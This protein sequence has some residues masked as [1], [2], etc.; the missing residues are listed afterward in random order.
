[1]QKTHSDPLSRVIGEPLAET[2]GAH[3]GP[4][5]AMRF[6]WIA[7]CDSNLER[8]ITFAFRV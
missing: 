7:S 6:G 2:K 4:P 1:M 8:D 5:F 3:F